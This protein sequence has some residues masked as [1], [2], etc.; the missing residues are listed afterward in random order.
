MDTLI[1]RKKENATDGQYVKFND[2]VKEVSREVIKTFT[3]DSEIT[4]QSVNMN[5]YVSEV[6]SELKLFDGRKAEYY[7]TSESSYV[8]LT[9]YN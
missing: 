9:I 2:V 7:E 5:E 4:N 1:I 8:T 6:T 3:K